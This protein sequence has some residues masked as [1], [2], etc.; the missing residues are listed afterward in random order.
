MS[1]KD[2]QRSLQ[3][4]FGQPFAGASAMLQKKVDAD[5]PFTADDLANSI[6]DPVPFPAGAPVGIGRV[7][8]A[9]P[10]VR[11]LLKNLPPDIEYLPDDNGAGPTLRLRQNQQDVPMS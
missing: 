3:H 1:E 8:P 4:F 10:T 6:R 7:D 5:Q 9:H 2:R 11:E